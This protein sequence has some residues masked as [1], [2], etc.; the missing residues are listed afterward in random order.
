MNEATV[1][2]QNGADRRA[3]EAL[4]ITILSPRPKK[5]PEILGFPVFLMQFTQIRVFGTFSLQ[6]FCNLSK[7]TQRPQA[8][9]YSGFSISGHNILHFAK[10]PSQFTRKR[11]RL[12]QPRPAALPSLIC[13]FVWKS[14]CPPGNPPTPAAHN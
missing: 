13:R 4:R 1:W 9:I 5:R 3:V 14:P 11:H 12:E 7:Y 6:L 8:S 10:R 2:P